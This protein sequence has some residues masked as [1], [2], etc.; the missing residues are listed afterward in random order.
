MSNFLM[1]PRILPPAK[2]TMEDTFASCKGHSSYLYA[3]GGRP[4]H[5][6][7]PAPLKYSDSF[8]VH[9]CLALCVL[10]FKEWTDG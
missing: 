8:T 3:H 2:G 4:A 5:Y 7:V 9:Y 1:R 6:P 10:I